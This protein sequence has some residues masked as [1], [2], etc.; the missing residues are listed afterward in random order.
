MKNRRHKNQGLMP[1]FAVLVVIACA[2]GL[3][4]T[5]NVHCVVEALGSAVDFVIFDSPEQVEVYKEAVK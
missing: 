3:I 1:Y 2:L 5:G 4:V